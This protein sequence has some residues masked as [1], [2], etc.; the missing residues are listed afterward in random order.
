MLAGAVLPASLSGL[1]LGTPHVPEV[2]FHTS[3]LDNLLSFNNPGFSFA[4]I[5]DALSM[6]RDLLNQFDGVQGVLSTP[7]PLVDVSI[8]DLLEFADQFS[9]ALQ[10][11]QNDPAASLQLLDQKIS[12]AFG[13]DPAGNLLVFSLDDSTT[14]NDSSDDVL[15][16]GLNLAAGF[17]RSLSV[18]IPNV[19]DLGA[20]GGVVDFSGAATLGASGNA[21]FTLDIGIGLADPTQLFLY[22][23]SG[24]TGALAL[25]GTDLAFKAGLGPF[26][27]SVIG[28]DA[29]IAGTIGVAFDAAQFTNGRRQVTLN[30]V[31]SVLTNLDV[32]LTAPVSATLPVYF[33]TESHLVGDITLLGDLTDLDEP[34]P[35][36]VKTTATPAPSNKIVLDVSDVLTDLTSGLTDLSLLDQILFIVDGVDV[37]LG[38]VQDALDG[39]IMGFS[40]PLIGDKLAEGAGVIGDFRDGFLNDFRGEIEKLG[41]PSENGIKDILFKLLGGSNGLLIKTD[42]SGNAVKDGAGKFVAGDLNDIQTFSNLDQATDIAAPRSGGKSRSVRTC[43]TRA[44]TSDSTWGS[45][46]WAWKPTARFG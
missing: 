28:G 43:S 32:T 27:L 17:S 1:T 30:N 18:Q 14:P 6:V 36:F 2:D 10:Q 13:V 45:R 41:N 39:D 24:L 42:G 31:G 40:L 11:M 19:V 3:N 44:L 23:S 34:S 15:K 35:L 25:T 8:N 37:V 33:P 12:E 9:D 4:S 7:I 46:A 5:I 21:T 26:S 22:N 16:L 38:G 20:L 29:S